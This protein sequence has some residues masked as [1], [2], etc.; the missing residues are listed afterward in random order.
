[1]M[2][3]IT[4]FIIF[5]GFDVIQ[6][7]VGNPCEFQIRSEEVIGKLKDTLQAEVILGEVAVNQYSVIIL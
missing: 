1:M 5:D 2:R 6:C 4:F 7:H 3:N